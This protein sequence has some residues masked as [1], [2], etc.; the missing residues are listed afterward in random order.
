VPIVP[1][2][3]PIAATRAAD[4]RESVL[5]VSEPS[6]MLA[7]DH[8]SPVALVCGPKLI[9]N[10]DDSISLSAEAPRL[11]LAAQDSIQA[12]TAH[13]AIMAKSDDDVLHC[14]LSD[15]PPIVIMLL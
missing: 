13:V 7:I 3:A 2:T 11:R 10:I 1:L 5:C 6:G 8:A 9:G 12:R 4:D 14:P 15:R